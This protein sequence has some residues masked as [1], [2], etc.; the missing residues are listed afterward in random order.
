LTR[1]ATFD[2]HALPP[3]GEEVEAF[4]GD[5]RPDAEAFT[6]LVDRLL[7]SPRFGERWG[8]HWLDL[9]RYADERGYIGVGVDR[10][11]PFAWTY[12]DYVIR[13]FNDDL[14]YDRFIQEQ[15]AADL[16]PREPD[17]D[18]GPLAALGFLTVGRRFIN[19]IHDIIDDRIDVVT[20]TTL[21]L[22]VTC[23]RCHDHKYDPISI[24]EYYG[25]YGVFASTR[26]P[27][28]EQM[29]L[30]VRNPS[31][32]EYE[33][34]VQELEQRKAER[35][36]FEADHAEM[37]EKEPR[38]FPEQVKPFDNRIRQVHARHPG[39]PPRGMVL[40]EREKPVEPVVFLRGN[41][42]QRGPRVP[43]QFLAFLEKETPTPFAQGSGRLELAQ[44]ITRPEN[45]L[46]ARVFVNRAWGHLFGQ[47]LV[48]TLS[49]F[50]LRS[51]PPAQ[52]ELLDLLAIGFV[53]D[54]WSTKRLVRRIMLSAAYQRTSDG[55]PAAMAA[56]PDNRWLGR[57]NRR[58]VDF[59][60]LRDGILFVAGSMDDKRGGPSVDLFRPP[61]STRRTVYGFIDRQ[62]LP[63]VLRT[64]DFASPDTHAP[65][66]FSTTV[67]QQAL[68]LMNSPLV[69]EQAEKLVQ[70]LD[71]QSDPTRRIE[72]LYRLV[73]GRDPRPGELLLAQGFLTAGAGPPDAAAWTHLAQTLFMANEFLYVD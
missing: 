14:P 60:A 12:R 40:N 59:E 39:A 38:K 17:D 61:F 4:L 65:R 16:L 49:D 43:R 23:A 52:D 2:L 53:Q 57:Q 68:F 3:T 6:D 69:L 58:R 29:P 62:N 55:D 18:P 44:A 15:L 67:P 22:T 21:G 7:A 46:T 73:L 24:G 41:P 66:R 71:D 27:D 35:A 28:I 50:G 45:P 25:L 51:E 11:Y 8:R 5:R 48:A 70:R 30:L 1:R 37:K 31:G 20:R 10:V 19:N 13:A 9:A 64:F 26:E 33:A 47:P 42:H 63:G 56:D 32:P 34:F 54:G 36:K 72:Q